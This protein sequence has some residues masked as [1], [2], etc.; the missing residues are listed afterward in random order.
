M[1]RNVSFSNVQ[2]LTEL[3][4][5]PQIMKS[6]ALCNEWLVCYIYGTYFKL[7]SPSMNM[8]LESSFL[9]G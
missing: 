5:I 3:R 7:I 9:G 2:M 8:F 1:R 4:V 6:I